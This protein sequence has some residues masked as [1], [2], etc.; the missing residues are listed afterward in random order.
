MMKL[1]VFTAVVA[2]AYGAYNG[3]PKQAQILRLE[4][5]VSPD[6]AYQYG[7]DTEN[8]ISAQES[9]VG[10]QNAQGG[11]QYQSPEGENVQLQYVADENGFAAQGSHVP[12]PPPT[13]AAILRALEWIAAHPSREDATP[14][15]RRF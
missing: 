10:A 15:A 14:T 9:G 3:D 7:Y 4:S 13:P 8:G 12:T 1:V 5:D 11:F 6:G 2:V